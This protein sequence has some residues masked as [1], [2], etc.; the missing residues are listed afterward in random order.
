MYMLCMHTYYNMIKQWQ[1][2]L[3]KWIIRFGKY[4]NE[5]IFFVHFIR[6]LVQLI[7]LHFL[8]IFFHLP[9]NPLFFGAVAVIQWKWCSYN[10]CLLLSFFICFI[11]CRIRTWFWSCDFT[12]RSIY[13][14][15][16]LRTVLTWWLFWWPWIS[17]CVFMCV[18]WYFS[19][20]CHTVSLC[21]FLSHTH[22]LFLC[23]FLCVLMWAWM[24]VCV[25]A[26]LTQI[27][28]D[29]RNLLLHTV[30]TLI[31]I[32]KYKEKESTATMKRTKYSGKLIEWS[33]SGINLKRAIRL[34]QKKTFEWNA[35]KA[36]FGIEFGFFFSE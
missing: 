31:E 33:S 25:C 27:S 28:T 10:F 20:Q 17:V 8:Y 21:L 22:A 36:L 2:P 7:L 12:L 24:F 19:T 15:T 6:S 29:K 35:L 11:V 23:I 3:Y 18:Y 1:K 34:T 13:V 5:C 9:Q 4:I 32:Q 30:Y 16:F 14:Y 26:R